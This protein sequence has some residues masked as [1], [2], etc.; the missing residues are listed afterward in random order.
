[1]YEKWI[2]RLK[3]FLNIEINS[4]IKLIRLNNMD[5]CFLNLIK[6]VINIKW[7]FEKFG[8]NFENQICSVHFNY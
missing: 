6:R 4:H 2:V 3:L 5:V 7:L 1:M 8:I